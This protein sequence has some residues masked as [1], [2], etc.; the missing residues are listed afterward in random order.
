M[1]VLRIIGLSLALSSVSYAGDLEMYATVYR[2]KA[3]ENGL[4]AVVIGETD[5]RVVKGQKIEPRFQITRPVRLKID[6]AKNK[7]FIYSTLLQAM[8]NRSWIRITFD[9]A[10]KEVSS[11][12]SHPQGNV[13]SAGDTDW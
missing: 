7:N 5:L 2:V 13:V 12:K 3:D 10:T 11:V 8:N 4:S 1:K 6:A 9:E